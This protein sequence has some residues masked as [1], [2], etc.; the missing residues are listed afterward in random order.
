MIVGA[1]RR[2][3]VSRNRLSLGWPTEMPI[4]ASLHVLA[5][6]SRRWSLVEKRVS[7]CDLKHR[8][9]FRAALYGSVPE[10]H[11]ARHQKCL[12][13]TGLSFLRRAILP[14]L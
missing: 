5:H 2:L 7:I 3:R 4:S 10:L 11:P 12:D 8:C 6:L 14:L 9:R 1:R 13:T